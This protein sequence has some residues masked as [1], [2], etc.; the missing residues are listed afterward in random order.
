MNEVVG[1]CLVIIVY[2]IK[3]C[4]LVLLYIYI[5]EEDLFGFLELGC[6]L[7]KFN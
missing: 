2:K 7:M 4:R 1:F 6:G 5:I 3:F